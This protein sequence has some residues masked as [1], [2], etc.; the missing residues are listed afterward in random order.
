MDEGNRK[1][2][3]DHH[4]NNWCRQAPW[5][6]AEICGQNFKRMICI[7]SKYLSKNSKKGN[8]NFKVIVMRKRKV[9]CPHCFSDHVIFNELLYFIEIVN[10]QD[11]TDFRYTT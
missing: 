8:N 10:I 3:S 7:I 6:E 2:P 5:I 11:C 1:L 9:V 4:G